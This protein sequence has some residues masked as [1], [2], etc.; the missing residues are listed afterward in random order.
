MAAKT[1]EINS[2]EIHLMKPVT[3]AE[4]NEKTVLTNSSWE[5]VSLWLRRQPGSR[6]K[7]A[8]FYWEQAKSFYDVIGTSANRVETTNCLLTAV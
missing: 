1:L 7:R 6:A 3:G 8:L 2:K 4:Y 5:F